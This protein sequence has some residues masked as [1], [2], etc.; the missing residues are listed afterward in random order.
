MTGAIYS[1]AW[2]SLGVQCCN[3]KL[4]SKLSAAGDLNRADRR[5]LQLGVERRRPADSVD[6]WR[7]HRVDLGCGVG[8]G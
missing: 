2:I 1:L 7:G 3:L 8:K 4:L 5:D 6:V